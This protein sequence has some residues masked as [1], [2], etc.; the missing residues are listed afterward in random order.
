MENKTNALRQAGRRLDRALELPAG[1]LGGGARIELLADREATIDG[2]RGIL[3]YSDEAVRL[4]V[5]NGSVTFFGRDLTLK[6]LT[7]RE[8]ILGGH[9]HRVEF[10]A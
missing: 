9:I 4:N 7:D 10:N 2:C 3:S 1:T 8:A 6:A 5:G